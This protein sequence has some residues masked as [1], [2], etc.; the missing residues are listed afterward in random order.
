MPRNRIIALLLAASCAPAWSAP[1]DP[2]P[3]IRRIVGEISPQR[4][5]ATIRKLVSFH[6][7]HT[8][9]E[10]DSDT[11]GIGAAR[12]W[13]KSQLESCAKGTPLKVEFDDHLVQRAQ[14]IDK[15]THVVNVVATLPGTQPESRDRVYVVSG[16]YDSR[17]SQANDAV[18]FAPGANDDGSGTALAMELACVMARHRFDA[19]LVFM[20]VAG[21]EQ[22]LFGA[23][24]YAKGARAKNVDI[25]G[26]FTNDIVGN[27]RGEDGSLHRGHIRLFA[28][29]VPFEKE[30]PA[31]VL[32]ALRTSGEND[33][34]TRQ[35]ARFI[36]DVAKT[37]VPAMTVDVVWRRDRYL[38][39][40]DHIAFLDEGYPAVRFTEPVEDWRRQHQDV[41]VE[42]GVQWGDLPDF[43]DY[44]QVA[45]V[46][47]VNGAALAALALAPAAPK[48][49]EIEAIKLEMDTT[50]RWQANPEPDVAGYRIVWRE[51]T[52]PWWQHFRDVGNVTR[53]TLEGVSKDDYLFSVQAYDRDGNLSVATY[54]VPT[55]D[56]LPKFLPRPPAASR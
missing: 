31:D 42:N 9:S 53:Y 44:A 56:P 3:E 34:P 35:L 4:I 1:G 27:T 46:A 20:A 19:T 17:A 45:D 18:S 29:G 52:A 23:I 2:N 16:H 51:T 10:T 12:R 5:E 8:L 14:R 21:E 48:H 26:M 43:V 7:R 25:Q 40:G 32:E 47:R 13:I 24:G 41:R 36:R 54:P 50:L 6:T 33:L 49:V 55:R 30:M 28:M 15:P 11:R 39:G 37:Y 38:R 22:G